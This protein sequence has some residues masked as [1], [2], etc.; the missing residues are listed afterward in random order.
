MLR[1]TT[2]RSVVALVLA[3]WMPFCCCTFTGVLNVCKACGPH[4]PVEPVAQATP[5]R[6][7]THGCH[8]GHH[9]Q[10]TTPADSDRPS[11]HEDGPCMCGKDTLATIGGEPISI[12]FPAFLLVCVLPDWEVAWD[13]PTLGATMDRADL[14]LHKPPTTLLRLH[15]ALTI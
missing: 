6:S 5:A 13:A 15:C 7:S 14:A 9:D 8:H 4:E 10:E 1:S 2:F 3:A 11:H 12:D